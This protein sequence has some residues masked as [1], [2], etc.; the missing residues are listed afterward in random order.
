MADDFTK[1]IDPLLQDKTHGKGINYNLNQGNM[2]ATLALLKEILLVSDKNKKKFRKLV[3]NLVK[4][5]RGLL[6]SGY[7]PDY[8]VSGVTDPFLQVSWNWFNE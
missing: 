8:D 4:I 6:V 2:L 7:A 5:L 1:L 3:P